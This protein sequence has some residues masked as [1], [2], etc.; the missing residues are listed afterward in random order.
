M[1]FHPVDRCRAPPEVVE[2]KLWSASNFHVVCSENDAVPSLYSTGL[3]TS[4]STSRA[5]IAWKV[6]VKDSPAWPG[7][8]VSDAVAAAS[9]RPHAAAKALIAALAPVS[10]SVRPTP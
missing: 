3:R 9:W 8:V 4:T 7:A 6:W 5:F 2:V 1:T 10:G